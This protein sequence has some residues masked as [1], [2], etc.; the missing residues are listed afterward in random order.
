MVVEHVLLGWVYIDV[1]VPFGL[2]TNNII[3]CGGV[4]YF[5]VRVFLGVVCGVEVVESLLWVSLL[6]G[7]VVQCDAWILYSL[8]C[9]YNGSGS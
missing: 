9:T 1:W 4:L 3:Y 8:Y 2:F 5:V 7:P 6:R